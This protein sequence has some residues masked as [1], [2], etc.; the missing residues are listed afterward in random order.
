VQLGVVLTLD[1]RDSAALGT[2]A[3][4]FLG[5]PARPFADDREAAG[6][7]VAYDLA[8]IGGDQLADLQ[9][10]RPG[11]ILWAHASE[12]TQ[13]HPIAGDI[14]TYLYQMNASPWGE[15]LGV[16]EASGGTRRLPPEDAPPEELARRVL[17]TTI[18]KDAL[19]DLD[20]LDRLA[21]AVETSAGDHAAGV[22][23]SYGMRRRQWSGGPVPSSRFV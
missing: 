6:L 2:A 17:A 3:A 4:K 13:D 5:L 15:R 12:W 22:F 20:A 18:E 1:D 23:R 10:H 19:A 14:V 21:R 7:V 9:Q 16:D 8:T 11:Q